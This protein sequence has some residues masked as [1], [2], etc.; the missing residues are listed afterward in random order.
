MHMFQNIA[1]CTSNSFEENE[2][3]FEEKRESLLN[4]N[5]YLSENENHYLSDRL[6]KMRKIIIYQKALAK[7]H[8]K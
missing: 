6:R 1:Q 8:V 3:H 4:V 2:N 5:H 7:L